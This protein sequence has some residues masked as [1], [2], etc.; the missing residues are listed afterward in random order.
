MGIYDLLDDAVSKAK[1]Q[2][3]AGEPLIHGFLLGVVV[4]TSEEE[5]PGMVKVDVYI[6]DKE[7]SITEWAPVVTAYAGKNWG[8]FVMPEVNDH[9]LVGFLNGNFMQPFVLGSVYKQKDEFHK[10]AKH[11][12]N[13]IKRFK[14]PNG[15]EVTFFDEPD[16]GYIEMVTKKNLQLRLDDEKEIM[17]IKDKDKKNALEIDL[18]KGLVKLT[19]EKE[20][21]L[22]SSSAKV[23]IKGSS[24][25]V[26]VK[27]GTFK[28]DANSVKIKGQSIQV[29]GSMMNL[30]ASGTMNVK[31]DGLCNVKG[32]MVKIN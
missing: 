24:N 5:F 8:S 11:K 19:G 20:I 7:K 12:K 22:E 29:E 26:S 17:Y 27:T 1:K 25:E 16:K 23:H 18:K 2:N 15:I 9:V 30:N 31:S 3:D 13:Y 10:K 32:S 14:T 6:R 21:L 28:V 4:N